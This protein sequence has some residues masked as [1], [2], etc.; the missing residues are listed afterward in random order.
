MTETSSS[1]Y[2]W[3]AAEVKIRPD[4]DYSLLVPL[5][6]GPLTPRAQ[7]VLTERLREQFRHQTYVEIVDDGTA[8]LLIENQD[9]FDTIPPEFRQR[10]D[11]AWSACLA[12]MQRHDEFMIGNVRPW[13]TQLRAG[14]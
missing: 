2:I 11:A 1:A 12:Q 10:F 14:K 5:A 3:T 9:M 13:L 8:V 4:G 6:T 7:T